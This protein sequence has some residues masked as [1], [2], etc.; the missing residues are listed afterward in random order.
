MWQEAPDVRNLRCKVFSY[1]PLTG[2]YSG[3]APVEA[4]CKCGQLETRG[5]IRSAP[6]GV[7]VAPRRLLRE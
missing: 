6:D 7:R 5:K 4:K 1:A 2:N 3:S